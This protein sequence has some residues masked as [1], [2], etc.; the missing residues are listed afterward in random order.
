[1]KI[2]FNQTT[3]TIIACA[4][5]A[6][7][8]FGK[9]FMGQTPK[10]SGNR[11]TQQ[12]S[13]QSVNAQ[14]TSQ[15]RFN[16]E[17]KNVELPDGSQLTSDYIAEKL[18]KFQEVPF[19]DKE[20]EYQISLPDTWIRSNFAQF[21]L[22]NQDKYVLLTNIARYFGPSLGDLRP[23]VW[24]EALHLER[25]I[26]ARDYMY[27][28]FT[29]R[30]LTPQTVETASELDAQA[31]FTEVQKNQ[32]SYAIHARF[33][34]SGDRLVILKFGVPI[35]YY[36]EFKDIMGYAISSFELKQIIRRK[37]E[38]RETFKLLNVLSFDHLESWTPAQVDRGSTLKTGMELQNFHPQGGLNGII[39]I[40]AYRKM[41]NL[42][43]AALWPEIEQFLLER[44][45]ALLDQK[46]EKDHQK[47]ET[48]MKYNQFSQKVY[49][50][51]FGDLIKKTDFDIDRGEKNIIRQT[52]YV[53]RIDNDNHIAYFMLI[54]P[55]ND[56]YYMTWA[57]NIYAYNL[58]LRSLNMTEKEIIQ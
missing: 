25:E 3:V 22:P 32:G 34:I 54:T 17:N 53:T 10:S 48:A 26:T 8:M 12:I 30:G 2:K 50:V 23:F 39:Y 55:D 35:Q 51:T 49:D 28:Y 16:Q 15:A 18:T 41:K 5:M 11:G 38:E 37:I 36:K 29:E 57:Q 24:F 21:G 20:L 56:K 27:G 52:L 46:E 6:V 7:F 33:M 13:Q 9:N 40:K 44:G 47:L 31:L 58:L 19:G 4:A 42:D 1:M 45:F 14:K 43:E